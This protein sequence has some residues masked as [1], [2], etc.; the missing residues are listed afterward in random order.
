M[1]WLS[2]SNAC[3]ASKVPAASFHAA[4]L[5]QSQH[6]SLERVDLRLLHGEDLVLRFEAALHELIERRCER[7]DCCAENA[8][9]GE[10]P[11]DR[12]FDDTCG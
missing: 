11:R 8:D 7:A 9:P 12:D 6:F 4:A 3:S 10:D 2:I 5:R 1:S